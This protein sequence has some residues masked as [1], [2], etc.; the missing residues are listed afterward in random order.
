ME[1]QVCVSLRSVEGCGSNGQKNSVNRRLFTFYTSSNDPV[2]DTESYF[3]W[4]SELELEFQ[5]F[6]RCGNCCQVLATT[7]AGSWLSQSTFHLVTCIEQH[8]VVDAQPESFYFGVWHAHCLPFEEIHCRWTPVIAYRCYYH[9][10]VLN[11]CTG[12]VFV[13]NTTRPRGQS[14]VTKFRL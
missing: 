3:N 8:A 13:C 1:D 4:K 11:L 5:E 10:V 12:K 6:S 14:A 7:F 2:W 9:Y